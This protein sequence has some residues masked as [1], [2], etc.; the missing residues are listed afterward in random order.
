VIDLHD[1]VA[2]GLRE[3]VEARLHEDLSSVNRRLDQWQ[4]PRSTPLYWAAWTRLSDV[5]GSRALDEGERLELV[6]LL[7][8]HGADPNLIAGDGNTALDVA[9]AADAKRITALLAAR[10]GKRAADL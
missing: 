1:A 7:L 9:I 4:V 3:H 8:D 10:G 2:F 6:K 5:D